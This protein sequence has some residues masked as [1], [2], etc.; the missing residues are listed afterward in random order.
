[1]CERDNNAARQRVIVWGCVLF[2]SLALWAG[3]G[4]LTVYILYALGNG[5][6]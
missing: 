2:A 1:M 6:A 3:F 4:V 5:G